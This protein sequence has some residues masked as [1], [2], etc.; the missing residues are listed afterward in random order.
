MPEPDDFITL[1][2]YNQYIS[3]QKN[4]PTWG[5]EI[6]VMV[7]NQKRY[8]YGNRIGVSNANPL[9]DTCLYEV[10]LPERSVEE[11]ST[12]ILVGKLFS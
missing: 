12:N 8:Q 10:E 2:E 6:L 5:D 1:E 4:I 7:C 9:L 11:I 3:S